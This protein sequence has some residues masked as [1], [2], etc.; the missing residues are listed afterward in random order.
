MAKGKSLQ[1]ILDETGAVIEGITTTT[2]VC[3]LSEKLNIDLPIAKLVQAFLDS[4]LSPSEAIMTL[5]NRPLV[6]E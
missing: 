3:N 5:M 2:A 6:S 4:S 1:S